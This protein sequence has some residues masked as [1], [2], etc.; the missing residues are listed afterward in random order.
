MYTLSQSHSIFAKW[1]IEILT[2]LALGLSTIIAIYNRPTVK[3]IVILS[4]PEITVLKGVVIYLDICIIDKQLY[5][6]C[7]ILAENI[8]A[9][10]WINQRQCYACSRRKIDG[11][12]L[13]W[14]TGML[15]NG[16]YLYCI[17]YINV[18][19]I[20]YSAFQ[21]SERGSSSVCKR[22]LHWCYSTETAWPRICDIQLL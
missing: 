12:E 20:K 8:T 22:A 3:Y 17:Y 1:S 11:L 6:H 4:N 13:I 15:Q 18:F 19:A 2:Q 7:R 9:N 5:I 14:F 10:F 16:W 21:R